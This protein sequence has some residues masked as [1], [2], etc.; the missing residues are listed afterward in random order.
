MRRR[1]NADEPDYLIPEPKL[2]G[3]GVKR[4]KKI[5]ER[6]VAL[7]KKLPGFEEKFT[8]W[9]GKQA[10]SAIDWQILRPTSMKTNLPRLE[11]LEDGS[12]FSTGD[13]TKLDVFTLRFKSAAALEALR[14]EVLPDDRLPAGGPGRSYYEGRKGDFFLSEITATAN[15]KALKFTNASRDYGKITTGSGNAAAAETYAGNTTTGWATSG[16]E[17][18]T[19]QRVRPLEAPHSVV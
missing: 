17:G 4:E 18:K 15:G 14:L 2:L 7:R 8:A 3:R 5:E 16:P 1:D 12:I 10:A 6:E 19:S 9:V 13:I 11:L